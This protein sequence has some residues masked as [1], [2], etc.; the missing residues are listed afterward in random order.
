LPLLICE[1]GKIV[2]TLKALGQ[3]QS[4]PVQ[5]RVMVC[6]SLNPEHN[7]ALLTKASEQ[8]RADGSEVYLV[9]VET[10]RDGRTVDGPRYQLCESLMSATKR[11]ANSFWLKSSDV[12]GALLDFAHKS[13][14]TR[15]IAYQHRRGLWTKIVRRSVTEQLIDRGRGMEI[16]IV[17]LRSGMKSRSRTFLEGHPSVHPDQGRAL[18]FPAALRR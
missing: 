5:K 10:P 14:I 3:A 11:G 12:A 9:H 6:L 13:Q 1:E 2:T 7:E 15:I 8:I 16:E 4:S 17:G 18:G